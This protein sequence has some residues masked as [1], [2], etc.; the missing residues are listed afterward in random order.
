M[1]EVTANW[2]NDVSGS[3]ATA[4]DWSSNAV[5]NNNSPAGTD[6]IANLNASGSKSYIVT[7]TTAETVDLL[8]LNAAATLSIKSAAFTIDSQAEPY[9]DVFN[10]GT[11]TVGAGGTLAFGALSSPSNYSAEIFNNGNVNL[12][13]K[14]TAATLSIAAPWFELNGTGTLTMS[15]AAQIIAPVAASYNSTLDNET[16]TIQ[17]SG[18]IGDGSAAPAGEG[19]ILQ[20]DARGT[21]NANAAAALVLNTGGNTIENTGLIETTG[22][23]GLTLDSTLENDGRLV[24]VGTG[25]LTV[26]SDVY[27]GGSIAVNAGAS[28]VLSNGF[29]NTSGTVTVAAGGEITT[30]SGDQGDNLN[31]GDIEDAGNIVV[32]DDSTLYMNASVFGSGA[33]SLDG[34]TG[35]TDLLIWNNGLAVYATGGIILS[36]SADN[37]IATGGP[38]GGPAQTSQQFSNH[39]IVSGSGT[40]GDGWLRLV[41]YAGSTVN[42]N[43]AAGMT[44]V[45]VTQGSEGHNYNAGLIE[46][47][48]AGGLV[49]TGNLDN[50]GQLDAAGSGALTLN[51]ATVSNGTGV[52]QTTAAG[53]SIVLDNAQIG[54]GNTVSLVA[55]TY[56]YTT[57]GDTDALSNVNNAGT[58]NVEDGSTLDVQGTWQNKGA[59]DL[60]GATAATTLDIAGSFYLAGGGTINL[61]T[62]NTLDAIGSDTDN[63]NPSSAF[64][65]NLNN[66][67]V[68]AG[69]IGDAGLN[70]T[71][72]VSGVIDAKGSAGH[73]LTLNGADSIENNGLIET[74]G[75]GGLVIEGALNQN[76]RLVD[77]GTGALTLLDANVAGQ[78]SA[79]VASKSASLVFEQSSLELQGAISSLGS[80]SVTGPGTSILSAG[81]FTN[82]GTVTISDAAA[83]ELNGV[84]KNSGSLDVSSTGDATKLIIED[85]RL[86]GAGGL[87]LSNNAANAIVGDGGGQASQFVNSSTISGAGVIGGD[88]LQLI[89]LAGGIIDADG[90]AVLKKKKVVTPAP[91]LSIVGDGDPGDN[92][93]Y[94]LIETTTAGGLSIS[95]TLDNNGTIDASGTGALTL[96]QTNISGVGVLQTTAAGA[97]ILMEGATVSA[98]EFALVAGSTLTTAD[99]ESYISTQG[100]AINGGAINIANGTTL[101][102]SQDWSNAGA[103]NLNGSTS[104]TRLDVSGALQLS[105]GG[106]VNL[107]TTNTDDS[108]GTDTNAGSPPNSYF[109][110]VDNTISGAGTIGDANMNLTNAVDGVIDATGG[111]GDA[112]T[113]NTGSTAI[114]NDGVIE[115]TGA[116]G[117]DID[118]AMNLNGSLIA[119]GTGALTI[120]ATSFVQNGGTIVQGPG[121]VQVG[122]GGSIVLFDSTISTAGT[123]SIAAT[124]AIQATGA[125]DEID[126]GSDVENAGSIVVNDGVT[127]Y[128][129][130][131]VFNSGALDLGDG[132]GAATLEIDGWGSNLYG[133]GSILL[134]DKVGNAIVGDGSPISFSSTNDI[135]GSGQIGDSEL[136]FN[137]QAGGIVDSTGNAGMTIVANTDTAHEGSDYNDGLIETTGAGGLVIDPVTGP[138][139][140]SFINAGTIE[141][142]GSGALTLDAVSFASGG[143][144]FETTGSGSFLLEDHSSIATGT[145]TI[146]SSGSLS[147]QIGSNN[148]LSGDTDTLESSVFNQGVIDVANG[149]NLAASGN[150]RN[151]NVVNVNG[152]SSATELEI[153]SNGSLKLLGGGDVNLNGADSSI[154]SAGANAQL[155][156]VNDTI[157][158]SGV[159]GDANMDIINNAGA[160]IDATGSGGL[161]IDATAYNSASNTNSIYNAGV[162]QSD[163]A[164]GV[165][166]ESAMSN[167]GSLIANQGL[168]DVQD[169]DYGVGGLAEINGSA[170]IEFGAQSSSDVAFGAS[171]SGTLI[172]DH[173]SNVADPFYGDIS[174][175]ASGDTIDLRDIAYTQ[176][177][178][179]YTA[180][181][182]PL[183]ATL[184]VSNASASSSLYLIGNYSANPQTEFT[185][186]S[187][188]HG[189]TKVTFT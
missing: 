35:P 46:T 45:G 4:A 134:S 89:N 51:G 108:I 140:A 107:A 77:S 75:A 148:T 146:S 133:S 174:G 173:S 17:G 125:S 66:T 187:D 126:N 170:S 141:A 15:G 158:G 138:T 130:A 1:V 164:G 29:V 59:V 181:A 49:V 42:S 184:T 101:D 48:G 131:T 83:L 34:A 179:Q 115:T 145:T 33:V 121:S 176:G 40:I 180:N 162:I 47:T 185:L 58:V 110:N 18:T 171:A 98:G 175:F 152:T 78:G 19:L 169:A 94:G 71:N 43:G 7:S 68:G 6:Y 113:L 137:N 116:G 56:L 157:E 182:G 70:I 30:T 172:L 21:I 32:A 60:R 132:S 119:E 178:T 38:V 76:G 50:A 160:T 62:T 166:I 149:T 55:A 122:A 44:I 100:A 22:A 13:S 153:A 124:G 20:N 74:T 9:S 65:D 82:A 84:V 85:V 3:F 150:W 102:L 123:I 73:T 90:A 109:T 135:S 93:N 67:I 92:S 95:G 36:D 144:L 151:T 27:G 167:Y 16:N 97:S 139:V 26:S 159:I 183:D 80:I 91:A 156:N 2:L 14:T 177:V 57:A 142:S 54:G 12:S 53:A 88:D 99:G 106:T 147:T 37:L 103:I 114:Q 5:P 155:R 81:A 28:L 25:A 112:L 11:I 161:T 129:N 128:L 86:S 31:A 24:A 136:Q 69:V 165:T 23:G 41:N 118:S 111:V 143:G 127:L 186:S 168:I 117:L 189:G 39:S 61:S 72:G 188:T 120:S 52:V 64:L 163:S 104:A 10:L 154:L 79:S 96:A 105:G 63:G 87:V 8:S